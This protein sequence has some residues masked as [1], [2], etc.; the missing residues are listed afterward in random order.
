VLH[1]R[2]WATFAAASAVRSAGG[3]RVGGGGQVDLEAADVD[4]IK[5]RIERLYAPLVTGQA[6]DMLEQRA[7]A[8]LALA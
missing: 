5:R 2:A 1:W 8:R 7:K 6:W 4:L 3:Q